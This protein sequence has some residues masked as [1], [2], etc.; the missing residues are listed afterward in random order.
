MINSNN[1]INDGLNSSC[2]NNGKTVWSYNQGVILGG[3]AALAKDTNDNSLLQPAQSIAQAAI[4]N[5]TDANDILHD[6]CEPNCGQDGP[7]FKGIF[8]RNLAILDR[9]AP[10]QQY[11]T[12][13]EA[14]AGSIWNND[15]GPNDE[16]GLIWSGPYSQGNAATQTSAIDCVL[17]AD[18]ATAP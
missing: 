14:N 4:S 18:E 13:L 12:F 17:A 6:A 8:T 9:A 16:F 11:V 3:L 1:L 5:L 7:Q 10:Q 2:H 15:L